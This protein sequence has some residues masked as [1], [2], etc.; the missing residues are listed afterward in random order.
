MAMGI[1]PGW[2]GTRSFADSF[3][4]GTLR[5]K[6]TMEILKDCGAHYDLVE[7]KPREQV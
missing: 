1:Q 6:T 5:L 4:E 3:E 7:Y 2:I